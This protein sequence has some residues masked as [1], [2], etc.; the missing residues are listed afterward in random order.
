[1]SILIKVDLFDLFPVQKYCFYIC[2]QNI[3]SIFMELSKKY[4]ILTET[5]IKT[6]FFSIFLIFRH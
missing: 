5:K 1:M 2:S 3:S 6:S 4:L